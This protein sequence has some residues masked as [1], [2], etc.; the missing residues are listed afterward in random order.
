M[1]LS[2]TAL[3]GPDSG[4]AA[5]ICVTCGTQFPPSAN[6]PTGC[7]I[8]LD[9]RQYVGHNGQ[10]WTTLADMRT[11]Y[12]NDFYPV[13][14]GVTGIITEPKFGIG[15]RAFLIETEQG[16]VLWETL[17]YLDETTLAEI[18][19]RGGVK[20]ISLSHPHYYSTMNEWSHALGDVPI[21]LPN[22]DRRYV[23]RIGPNVKFWSG[24][25]LEILPGLT[26]IRCAGHF[27]GAAVL[28]W[29]N[30][31]NGKGALFSGDTLQ[32]VSDRDWVSFMYSYPNTIPLD[33]A[34]IRHIIDVLQPFDYDILYGAF[35]GIVRGDA[36]DKVRR[37]AE[38]YLR[39]IEDPSSNA[40]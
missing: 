33:P 21:H 11:H 29:A 8:C 15:Q 25:T 27:P 23:M 2:S 14:P 7:P 38:R 6:P 18:E 3:N 22:L 36:K 13:E 17:T 4:D 35:G 20:A 10:Q 24:D 32:V 40:E 9:D 34:S 30:G 12:R 39:H 5:Y 31:A 19:R 26:I 16:N 1:S 28:H 37:S